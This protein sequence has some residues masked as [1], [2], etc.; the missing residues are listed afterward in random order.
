MKIF[1]IKKQLFTLL[2]LIFWFISFNFW[3]VILNPGV[4]STTVIDGMEVEWSLILLLNFAYLLYC[5]LPAIWLF[6]KP[7]LWLKMSLSVLFLIPIGILIFQAFNPDASNDYV[8]VLADYFLKNFLYVLIF[9]LTIISAVYYNLKILIPRFF[10]RSQFNLYLL[11]A[12]G[13]SVCAA[14][15]NYSLF[16]LFIDQLFPGLFFISY[17]KIWELILIVAG[18]LL[19]T[20]VLFLIGQYALMLIANRD[21]AQHELSALKAQINPHFLFNNLNTIY[22]MAAQHDERTADVI[23]KLS[24]FLRYVLYDTTCETVPLEKE[25]ETIKTYIGLQKERVNQEITRISL[26]VEGDLSTAEI[27]PLLLLPLAENCFK[28]GIGK[29]A[30]E[31]KIFIGYDGSQLIFKTENNIALREKTSSEESGGIGIRNVKKRLNLI[32]P[33]QHSLE[34]QEKEGVFILVMK[35]QLERI[36]E[37]MPGNQRS[38]D[39]GFGV[40]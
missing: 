25:V 36:P 12:L 26:H 24:D 13:L 4:E 15:L 11:S 37:R 35:I 32:Y 21:A 7:K 20:S 14:L 23:L 5:S 18:Y 33:Q 40:S 34:Y 17:F 1:H 3:T 22:S 16:D 39:I 9:H 31:I 6:K 27:S 8:V 38:L 19:F 30:G 2:H 29:D 28:H 10:S